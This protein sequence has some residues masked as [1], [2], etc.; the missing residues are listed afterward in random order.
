MATKQAE[1]VWRVGDKVSFRQE[2]ENG[3]TIRIHGRIAGFYPDGHPMA[4]QAAVSVAHARWLG[5]SFA[6]KLTELRR[7]P[8]SYRVN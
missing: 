7:E 4:D 2:F 8:D 1:T 3:K 5:W 6:P